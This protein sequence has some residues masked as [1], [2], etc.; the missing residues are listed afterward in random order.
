MSLHSL[1][2]NSR[3]SHYIPCESYL[4]L[5]LR[6]DVETKHGTDSREKS[7]EGKTTGVSSMDVELCLVYVISNFRQQKAVGIIYRTELVKKRALAHSTKTS[8]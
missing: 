4:W 1:I 5:K 3:S 6:Q 7:S 8:S 2:Y